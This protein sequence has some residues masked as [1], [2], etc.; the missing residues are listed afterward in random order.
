MAR[1]TARHI[2]VASEDKCNELKAAIEGG[3]DFA[4]LARDNSSC[5]SFRPGPDGQGVRHCGL[6]RTGRCRARP[7]QD[8]VRISPAGS[9]QPPGLT[10]G[11]SRA[12]Y[13][14]SFTPSLYQSSL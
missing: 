11:N 1:A 6:Q 12:S 14:G 7:G 8:P 5:P 10:L 13:A 3:A 2:L 9:Y 4:Q